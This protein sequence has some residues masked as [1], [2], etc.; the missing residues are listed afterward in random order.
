M[1]LFIVVAG[2]YIFFEDWKGKLKEDACRLFFH[3]GCGGGGD[4]GLEGRKCSRFLSTFG[5]AVGFQ[6]PIRLRQQETYSGKGEENF[7]IPSIP[8]P[9]PDLVAFFFLM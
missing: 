6:S 8:E 9:R 4:G 5:T 3:G 1:F 7:E 2:V